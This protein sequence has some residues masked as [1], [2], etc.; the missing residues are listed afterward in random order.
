M[1]Q[2]YRSMAEEPIAS[3]W[4]QSQDIQQYFLPNSIN[5]F[6]NQPPR[7][8]G[9]EG[10]IGIFAFFD[11]RRGYNPQ[12]HALVMDCVRL[13]EDFTRN[14]LTQVV[15]DACYD[16]DIAPFIVK[17][18]VPHISVCIFQE[19]PRLLHSKEEQAQWEAVGPDQV[20]ALIQS[21][22]TSDDGVCRDPIPQRVF[23]APQLPSETNQELFPPVFDVRGKSAIVLELDSIVWTKDGA[24]IAGFRDVSDNAHADATGAG[25]GSLRQTLISQGKTVLSKLTTRPKNLIHVTLGRILQAPKGADISQLIREYNSRVWPEKV[26]E[27]KKRYQGG[28]FTLTHVTLHRNAVWLCEEGFYYATWKLVLDD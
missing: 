15:T 17:S 1:S 19:A 2:I 3:D 11:E 26:K 24:L 6:P 25:F 22:L 9:H 7:F 5:G 12:G 13:F 10:P 4:P 23:Q 14:Q 21:V 16:T 8:P 18:N 27:I 28:R 20:Q